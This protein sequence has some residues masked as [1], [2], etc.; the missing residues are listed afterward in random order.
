VTLEVPFEYLIN[1]EKLRAFEFLDGL[2]I[3]ILGVNMM[4]R[5]P[6][7]QPSALRQQFSFTNTTRS[8]ESDPITPAARPLELPPVAVTES[9]LSV[10]SS[11]PLFAPPPPQPDGS[12][13][14]RWWA[15]TKGDRWAG[16]DGTA[17]IVPF[18]MA[19]TPGMAIVVQYDCQPSAYAV[20]QGF[21]GDHVLLSNH[22]SFPGLVRILASTINAVSVF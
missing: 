1:R 12:L 7:D 9:A 22:L 4:M 2:P 15:A 5:F 8:I 3:R 13:E 21:E 14:H 16:M 19:L 11:R 17:S 6:Q 20:F 10:P 18:L